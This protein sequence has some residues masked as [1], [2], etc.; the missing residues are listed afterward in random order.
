MIVA[1]GVAFPHP[2]Y[3]LQAPDPGGTYAAIDSLARE[4]DKEAGVF[5][6]H[7]PQWR[8]RLQIRSRYPNR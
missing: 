3:Y 5:S 1:G 6:T 8:G 2:V 4:I 7:I